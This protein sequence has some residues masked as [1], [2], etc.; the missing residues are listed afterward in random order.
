MDEK[1]PN[2]LINLA[3]KFIGYLPDLL[4][5]LILVILGWFLG[6]FAKRVVVQLSIILRL[7]RF[8]ISFRW[9]QGFSRGDVRYGFYNFLGNIVFFIIFL[10][11]LNTAFSA[12]RLNVLSDLLGK[13]I[14]FLPRIMISLIMF[15]VGWLISSWSAQAMYKSLHR[16]EIPRATLIANFI[17]AVLLVFFSAIALVELN[18]AREIVIIGFAAIMITLGVLTIVIV[19]LGGKD[20]I[21]QVGK[22]LEE[23]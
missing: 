15:G 3:D 13:G 21:Q 4:G 8:L 16:E 6:W 1:L 22:T 12:W 9:G 7:E 19:T 2:L 23:E 17:K 11:F 14:L 20:F 10:I 5:G 18:I